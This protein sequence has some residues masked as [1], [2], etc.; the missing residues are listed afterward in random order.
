M[1]TIV[2]RDVPYMFAISVDELRSGEIFELERILNVEPNNFVLVKRW[3]DCIVLN[4]N[5]E[6]LNEIEE[7]IKK[8][9]TSKYFPEKLLDMFQSLTDEK[10]TEILIR[11]YSDWRDLIRERELHNQAL[12]MLK[13]AKG[14]R[15][16]WK[17]KKTRNL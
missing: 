4:K 8:I 6:N 17:V 13:S 3:K 11:Y 12:K 7:I 1:K 2:T 15:I 9:M 5:L 16:S 14:L 10:S